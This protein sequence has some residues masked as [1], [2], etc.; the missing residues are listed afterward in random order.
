[1][2]GVQKSLKWNSLLYR[3]NQPREQEAGANGSQFSPVSVT[4]C[5]SSL[6]HHNKLAWICWIKVT[7][8]YSCTQKS[9]IELSS[10][11]HFLWR[12]CRRTVLCFF[13]LV[14]VPDIPQPA[15]TS[16]QSPPLSSHGLSP[17]VSLCVLCSPS[18][19]T[20]HCIW[21][22]PQIQDKFSLSS[23]SNHHYFRMWSSR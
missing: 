3:I 15:A 23:L 9:K 8:I 11:P 20:S 22:S 5:M 21:D 6:G 17:C 18:N 16:I 7:N 4:P 10:G 1:M 14:V 19:D 2:K 12:L 13:Q